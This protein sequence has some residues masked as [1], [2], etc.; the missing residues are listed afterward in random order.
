MKIEALLDVRAA[1][2]NPHD[3]ALALTLARLA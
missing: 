1:A 3:F 2:F